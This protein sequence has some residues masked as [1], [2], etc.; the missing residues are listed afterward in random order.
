MRVRFP[1]KKKK[2][3]KKMN[4]KEEKEEEEEEKRVGW[5]SEGKEGK[6]EKRARNSRGEAVSSTGAKCRPL[7]GPLLVSPP[8]SIPF[9]FLPLLKPQGL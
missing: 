4:R 6:K 2:R 3:E 7:K 5:D 8:A 9:L 1:K